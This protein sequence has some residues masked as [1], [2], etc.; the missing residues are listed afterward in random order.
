LYSFTTSLAES[1]A[2]AFVKYR[3]RTDIAAAI[4]QIVKDGAI[5]THIMYRAFMSYPQLTEYLAMLQ[6]TGMLEFDGEQKLFITTAKGERFL[7]MHENLE[8]MFAKEDNPKK[9]LATN[10]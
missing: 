4:L 6:E 7:H 1:Y 5:K 2:C 10:Q 3:S 8:K 9:G